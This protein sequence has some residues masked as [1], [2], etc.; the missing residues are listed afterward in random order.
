MIS[1]NGTTYVGTE[2]GVPSDGAMDSGPPAG[3]DRTGARG[4]DPVITR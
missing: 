1:T 3:D 2:G 4:P